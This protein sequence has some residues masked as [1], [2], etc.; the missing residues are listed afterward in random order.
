MGRLPDLSL[1]RAH[2]RARLRAGRRPGAQA[3]HRARPGAGEIQVSP[4]TLSDKWRRRGARS[5]SARR[6]AATTWATCYLFVGFYD[7][8]SNSIFVADTDYLESAETREV[9][10][11]YY[12]DWGEGAFTME[13]E[14]EPLMFAISDGAELRRG[15]LHAASAMARRRRKPSTRWTASTPTP[16]VGRSRYA[17]L[18]FRDGVLQAGL[19]LHGRGG[20]GSPREIT[21]QSGDKFTVIE[22]WLDLDER[23]QVAQAVTQ[24]GGTLA[25]AIRCSPGRSWTRPPGPYV[26][27]FIVQDLDGNEQ[28]SLRTGDSRVMDQK[29]RLSTAIDLQ[30]PD[31]RPI[32]GWLAGGAQPHS[33]VDRLR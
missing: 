28:Q 25:S 20:T 33:G 4:I 10:G 5:C 8:E 18:Y 11:V 23:G 30:L 21:P 19:R 24:E 3:S 31:R 26:V 29:T 22:K 6:S 14:W 15:A 32:L 7:Q 1:H 17:R 13:F 16:M 2:L 27:G 12:P 9:D